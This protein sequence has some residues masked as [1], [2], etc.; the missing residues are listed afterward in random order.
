MTFNKGGREMRKRRVLI[1]ALLLIPLVVGAETI[2]WT[3]PINWS[4]GTTVSTADKAQYVYYLRTWKESSPTLITYFGE[5][6]NGV[7]TWTDNILVKANQ[8]GTSSV[9][10]WVPYKAG[11]NVFVD[12]STSW[13]PE[14]G[15]NSDSWPDRKGVPYKWT[16][17]GGVVVPPVVAPFIGKFT[18][19]TPINKGQCTTLAWTTTNAT[20]AVVNQGVGA[21]TPVA[22]GS[23]SVC[24]IATTT[25]IMT[26]TGPGGT[27]VDN[28]TVVVTIP[29]PPVVTPGCTPPTGVTITK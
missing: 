15:P 23:K 27:A 25:Y 7:T 19:N 3:P 10:G 4:D 2:T 8:W 26:A 14:G 17:P 21:V 24:P 12:V 9:T 16:I 20:S 29:P 13:E 5:T 22:S 18:A 1:L 11:D 6:R 28:V